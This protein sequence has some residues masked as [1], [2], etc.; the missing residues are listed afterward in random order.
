MSVINLVD[1]LGHPV[2]TSIRNEYTNADRTTVQNSA[3]N[4]YL[5]YSAMHMARLY[6]VTSLNDLISG[7]MAIDRKMQNK[8]TNA[9][10]TQ[11]KRISVSQA[12]SFYNGHASV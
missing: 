12:I 9:E 11:I 1:C 10:R 4:E 5:V 8:H 2:I 7:N 6:A 3:Q